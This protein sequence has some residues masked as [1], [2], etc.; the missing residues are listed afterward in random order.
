MRV[1]GFDSSANAWRVT[2]EADGRPLVGL[3]PEALVAGGTERPGHHDVYAWLDRHARQI[4]SALITKARGGEPRA[5][6]DRLSLGE[7]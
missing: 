5:P 2:F 4:H 3:V 6:Y 1:E 7:D